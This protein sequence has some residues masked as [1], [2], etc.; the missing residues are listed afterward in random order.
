MGKSVPI[1]PCVALINHV[2]KELYISMAA[3][4]GTLLLST[5]VSLYQ[6][7]VGIVRYAEKLFPFFQISSFLG[8]VWLRPLARLPL[9]GEGK[10]SAFKRFPKALYPLRL[11]EFQLLLSSGGGTGIWHKLT[12]LL[13]GLRADLFNLGRRRIYFA[14]IPKV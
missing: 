11:V 3:I 8:L 10:E 14:F 2:I 7:T 4:I 6:S 9:I 12:L 1:Y 13:F 5:S